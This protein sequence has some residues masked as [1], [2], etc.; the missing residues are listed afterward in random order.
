MVRNPKSKFLLLLEG[1][2]HATKN[3]QWKIGKA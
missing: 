3:A 2:M 1:H